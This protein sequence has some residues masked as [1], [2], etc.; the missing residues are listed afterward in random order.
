MFRCP[1]NLESRGSWCRSRSG[2]VQATAVPVFRT[3]QGP[4]NMLPMVSLVSG[5]W[6]DLAFFKGVFCDR[7]VRQV[8]LVF[9]LLW[10][11]KVTPGNTKKEL[12]LLFLERGSGGRRVK[13]PRKTA[14]WSRLCT[15]AIPQSSLA[16]RSS[17]H[18]CGTGLESPNLSAALPN[19]VVHGGSRPH[20]AP[21]VRTVYMPCSC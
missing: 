6:G 20:I 18:P 19:V 14:I 4:G 2:R 13:R 11:K 10:G 7:E 1:W 3:C 21:I 16:R 17:S 8:P 9:V 5:L 15:F 12:L